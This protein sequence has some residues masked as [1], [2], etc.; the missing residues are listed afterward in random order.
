MTGLQPSTSY[1]FEVIAKNNAGTSSPSNVAQ[2]TTSSPTVSLPVSPTSLI[3][4]TSS[5]NSVKLIWALGIGGGK[6]TAFQIQMS[7]NGTSFNTIATVA[8]GVSSYQLS[9]LAPSTTY[10]FRVSAT[11]SAGSSSPSV[12]VN[13]TTPA[14]PSTTPTQSY[15][16]TSSPTLPKGLSSF[17]IGSPIVA[18][19]TSYNGGTY[20]ITSSG[21]A[22]SDKSD[23]FHFV[24]SR[25]VGDS[26]IIARMNSQSN[27]G[28]NAE[29][30]V[31]VRASTAPS[32]LFVDLVQTP[33]GAVQLQ[34]R[35][36]S[37]GGTTRMVAGGTYSNPVWL[38][39]ERSGNQFTGYASR[40]GVN[41]TKV[42]GVK[43][44]LP[45]AAL[46]GL[47]VSSSSTNSANTATFDNVSLQSLTPWMSSDIG[48]PS[49]GGSASFTS[50][51][52]SITLTGAGNGIGGTADQFQFADRTTSG[53]TRVAARLLRQSSTNARSEAGVMIRASS[54]P[55]S[56][57]VAIMRSAN[58]GLTLQ[59]RSATGSPAQ[60]TGS[61]QVPRGAIDLI[62]TRVGDTFTGYYSTDGVRFTQL[63]HVTVS[64]GT[65]THAGVA[66][67]S[68]DPR[69]LN[70][71]FFAKV[72]VVTPFLG[73]RA[74]RFAR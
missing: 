3:V 34:W 25:T 5:A 70:T 27:T 42:G 52:R 37:S 65:N 53:D 33:T 43:V 35:D 31:M 68:Q 1:S 45:V 54:D 41:Y 38:K 46:A 69:A 56:A 11:N 22:I 14:V 20:S 8:E 40:D 19:S 18:G 24:G 73:G 28:P 60:S 15:M 50:N 63:G 21:G 32:A 6:P 7:T 51:L 57:F 74:R 61:V 2:A 30:G 64:M 47:A 58:N 49:I 9:G 16:P 48:S 67:T 26:T 55:S 39:L 71:A 66:T 72:T 29:A 10:S 44:V 12:M 59:W 36:G 62:L 23:Q 13:A 17:D 4:I